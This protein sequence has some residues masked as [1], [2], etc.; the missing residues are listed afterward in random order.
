MKGLKWRMKRWF[1]LLKEK[2]LYWLRKLK[3]IGMIECYCRF[4]I[5]AYDRSVIL[6]PF[7]LK[8]NHE[9]DFY[10]TAENLI[11]WINRSNEGYRTRGYDIILIGK[12]DFE[13]DHANSIILADFLSGERIIF[14]I[15]IDGEIKK[16]E[17]TN[18]SNYRKENTIEIENKGMPN[19]EK[20]DFHISILNCDEILYKNQLQNCR[21]LWMKA[22]L[23]TKID[24]WHPTK[25]K[26]LELYQR[27][28]KK[29]QNNLE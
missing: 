26:P 28:K 1:N 17:T 24:D 22:I 20:E 15:Q 13:K 3:I 9:D 5:V 14:P 27:I 18:I 12:H 7:I 16:L 6:L 10:S 29:S 25:F 4:R 2:F 21:N 23:L 11:L 8:G 19:E